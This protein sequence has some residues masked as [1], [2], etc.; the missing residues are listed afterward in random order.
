MHKLVKPDQTGFLNNR[1]GVDNVRRALNLQ[2]IAAKRNT[3]SMLLSLDAEKAFDRLIGFSSSRL[4]DTWA[5][6]THLSN[7]YAYFIKTLNLEFE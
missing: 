3:P 4:S 2:S 5:S 7:G 1:Q 6:M